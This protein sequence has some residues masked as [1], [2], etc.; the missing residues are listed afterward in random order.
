MKENIYASLSPASCMPNC[1]CELPRMGEVILE[2][3]NTWS[4]VSFILCGIFVYFFLK[5]TP[6]RKLTSFSFVLLGLGSMAFHGTGTFIGQTLDVFAMYFLVSVFIFQLWSK[7][8]NY[9]YFS[10]FNMASL[11]TLYFIPEVRRWGFLVLVVGLLILAVRRLKWNKYLGSSVGFIVAGQI[12]WNL[13]RLKIVCDP[14]FFFNGH[15]FWHIFSALSA[16]S[17]TLCIKR[18]QKHLF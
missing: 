9:L 5:E 4:N 11:L 14:E 16:L 8:F 12:V 13:D 15:F 18:Y 3:G 1:W 2:P 10:L 6:N 7:K 17:F